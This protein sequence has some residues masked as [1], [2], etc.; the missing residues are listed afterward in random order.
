MVISENERMLT[1]SEVAEMLHLHSN[2]V[3][4]W[5]DSGLLKHY[6]VGPRNDRRFLEADVTKIVNSSTFGYK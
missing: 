3:R 1:T 5:S 2:T 6:R 4:R